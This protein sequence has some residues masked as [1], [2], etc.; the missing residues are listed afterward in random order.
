MICFCWSGFPQYAA[1]CVGAF[2]AQSHEEVVVVATRPKVPVLGMENLC[3]CRVSWLETEATDII[4]IDARLVSVVIVSGWFNPVFNRFVSRV[5][6]MGGRTVVMVDN[7]FRPSFKEIIK[8]IRFRAL[9]KRKY[10]RYIVPGASA[11]RLLKFYGVKEKD[12]RTNL[13]S[14]DASVFFNGEDLDQRPKQIVFVGQLCERKNVL[15]LLEAFIKSRIWERG[16]Q[17]LYFGSG[18]LRNE[19]I[20]RIVRHKMSDYV[21]VNDFMQPEQLAHEYRQSRAFVLPSI[22]EHWGLVVHEA[23]LSGCLL[24]LS[25]RVGAAE[26]LAGEWNA[27]LF[28]PKSVSSIVSSF[29]KM[30]SLSCSQLKKCQE[31]SLR[32]ANRISTEGFVKSLQSLIGGEKV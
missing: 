1:R 31:E 32:L 5:I 17:L 8:A 15:V 7:N 25:D 30:A 12:I 21:R 28:N 24:L 29:V 18:P 11:K 27:F 10:D 9:F 23:A 16:W 14:A 6:Q 13:Y 26:D 3:G 2:V 20:S 22:E 4:D 19:L